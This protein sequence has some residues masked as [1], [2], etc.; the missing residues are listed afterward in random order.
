MHKI[1]V[2]AARQTLLM[3]PSDA[4]RLIAGRSTRTWQLYESGQKNITPE[5]AG[6]LR[7]AIEVRRALISDHKGDEFF[8]MPERQEGMTD[9]A[10]LDYFIRSSAATSLF[11]DYGV[12]LVAE[13]S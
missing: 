11:I 6:A 7:D 4:A 2:K 12:E 8:A 10:E 5:A 9:K 1:E 3:R 13:N